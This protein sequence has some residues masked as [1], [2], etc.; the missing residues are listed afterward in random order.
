MST[1]HGSAIRRR[2]SGLRRLVFLAR[3]GGGPSSLAWMVSASTLRPMSRATGRTSQW[4][5]ST[6]WGFLRDGSK[7]E[8]LPLARVS[9]SWLADLGAHS[10]VA[11]ADVRLRFL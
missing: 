9:A 11:F 2:F 6:L 3:S 10:T 5:Q 4:M 1:P 7:L 8:V